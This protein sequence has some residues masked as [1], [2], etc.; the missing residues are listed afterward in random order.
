MK[1]NWDKLYKGFTTLAIAIVLILTGFGVN[2]QG[3]LGPAPAPTED[4]T[5]RGGFNTKVHFEQGGNQLTIESGGVLANAGS[6]TSSGAI[7]S[8]GSASFSSLSLAGVAQSGPTVAISASVTNNTRIAHGIGTTPTAE[9]CTPFG[10]GLITTTVYIS[11][12]N[13][14]SI[15]IGLADTKAAVVSPAT[16]SI[17]CIGQR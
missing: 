9:I 5:A 2:L 8:T 15:T 7:T 14:V 4:L 6:I 13:S 16:L 12:V 11:A 10:L 3:G 1:I 17:N